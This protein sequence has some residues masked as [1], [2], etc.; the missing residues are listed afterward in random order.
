MK[1]ATGELTGSV[2]IVAAVAVLTVFFFF[3]FWPNVIKKNLV[4]SSTC[5]NAVCDRGFNSSGKGKYM[6]TCR[7]PKR[8]GYFYCPY[9]G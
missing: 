4:D 6:V 3:F 2:I 7:H 1:E 9:K 5:S 8:T